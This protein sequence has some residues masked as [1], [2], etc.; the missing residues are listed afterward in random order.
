MI[1]TEPGPTTAQLRVM[2]AY[3][4]TGS[5]KAAAHECGIRVQT[6]RNHMAGLYVRLGVGGAMEALTK[7]GWVALPG[8]SPAPCGWV[9][10]CSRPRGHGGHH[11]GMR[12]FVKAH[13]FAE[14]ATS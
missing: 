9:A 12:A 1:G 5:Q 3:V 8:A 4:R 14:E 13:A 11:G 6:V 2:A 10:Y 7:L